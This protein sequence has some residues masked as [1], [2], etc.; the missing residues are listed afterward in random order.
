MYEK[1]KGMLSVEDRASQGEVGTPIAL[2]NEML[3]KLPEEFWRSNTSTILDPCFGNGT[4]LIEAIK[5]FR[6]F[7]H[8]IENIQER[9]Y[10][11]E[12]SHR[13]Y[14][15]VTKLFSNYNFRKLYKEDFLTKD[16]NNM[17]FDVI[18]GNPPYQDPV[19]KTVKL[20]TNFVMH[21]FSILKE[22]GS[23]SMVFPSMWTVRPDSQKG[24]KVVNLFKSKKITTIKIDDLREWFNVGETTG[25]LHILNSE[26]NDDF[27]TLVL[28]TSGRT[29]TVVYKGQ[30]LLLTE[31]DLIKESIISKS[32]GL[33]NKYS[34][35][36]TNFH[37]DVDHSTSK[38]EKFTSGILSE[39]KREGDVEI[40]WT[41]SQMY[42]T[43]RDRVDP[44]WRVIMN[45]S[46]N[47]YQDKNPDKY[48]KIAKGIG[49]TTACQSLLCESKEEAEN[50][51]SYV[52][53]KLYRFLNDE[54]KTSGFNTFI[55][56][57]PYLGTDK[58]WNDE[59][60]YSEF[61]LSKVEI[62]LVERTVNTYS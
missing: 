59:M 32:R 18:I 25:Y 54:Q 15:K 33:L 58:N 48:I 27:K 14:N 40:W 41:A 51:H 44:R 57:L 3:D 24:K 31:D 52:T 62:E 37:E 4:Y 50:I 49:S 38:E 13:L 2:A 7:G 8:S 26:N 42:Y 47:Y 10:G 39:I 20:W 5:R 43:N 28:S 11:C 19:K 60:L 17:K 16:F 61:G 22:S 45:I 55:Y 35:L 46:G 34:K 6:K 53:S 12:I 9:V 23:F 21:S 29:E 56:H 30:K 1:Y 36:I